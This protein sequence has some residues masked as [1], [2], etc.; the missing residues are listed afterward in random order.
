MGVNDWQS[1]T[2]NP[3]TSGYYIT[4]YW[5]DEQKGAFYKPLYW[6]GNT[7]HYPRKIDFTVV[8]YLPERFDYYTQAGLAMDR[9]TA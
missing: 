4:Y 7:W 9:R 6:D 8:A 3:P 5:N 2:A 1:S